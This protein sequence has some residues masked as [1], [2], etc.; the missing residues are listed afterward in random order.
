MNRR[1]LLKKIIFSTAAICAPIGLNAKE[2]T[3]DIVLIMSDDMGISDIGG[4]GGEIETPNLDRLASRGLKFRHFYCEPMCVPAR[5][6]LM[7]GIYEHKSRK[8]KSLDPLC[9]TAA[10]VLR[11][12]GYAT[13]MSGKWHLGGEKSSPF[14]K[15]F[16][17]YFGTSPLYTDMST[18]NVFCLS[19]LFKQ[20]YTFQ[21]VR[22]LSYKCFSQFVT[23]G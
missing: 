15:G 6:V 7:T 2:K 20:A 1:E 10:E 16:E 19:I 9:P 22:K 18:D 21:H 14:N 8:G 4:F 3:P 5:A 13:V 23:N 11:S 12:A 17:K